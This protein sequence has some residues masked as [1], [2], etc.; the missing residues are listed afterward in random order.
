DVEVVPVLLPG[1]GIRLREEPYTSMAPLVEGVLD[2]IVPALDRPFAFFGHSMGALVAFEI[3]HA[4]RGARRA[5]P[6]QVFVSACAP[7]HRHAAPDRRRHDLDE[8]RLIQL[9]KHLN[10]GGDAILEDTAIIRRRLPLLRAD[11]AV[12]ETYQVGDRRPLGC[13]LTVYGAIN[14]PIVT[15]A[16]LD[17]WRDYTAAS[18]L[19]RVFPGGHFFLMESARDQMMRLLGRELDVLLDRHARLER[20]AS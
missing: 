13:P 19:K 8:P 11:L 12:C 2:A 17:E 6:S 14:D 3:A 9:V 18:F 5:E 4:L 1:R 20:S 15:V 10:A 16:E 7:P